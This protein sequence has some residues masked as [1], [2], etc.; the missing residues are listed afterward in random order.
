[1]DFGAARGTP[2]FAA[3]SGY[4][5]SA[6]RAGGGGNVIRLKHGDGYATEYM[7]LQRFASG[8]KAGTD[9]RK[10]QLIGF[11]G[12][13]GLSTGPHL[14][15]GARHRGRYV[16]PSELTDVPMPQLGPRERKSFDAEAKPLL[17]LMAALGQAAGDRS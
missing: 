3:A 9:V 15:Y 4:L 11:V 6:G 12:S 2:V 7:H 17:D 1:M 14:H 10:G 16:D 13:T 8:L 5:T